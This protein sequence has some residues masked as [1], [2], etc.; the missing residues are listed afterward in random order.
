[1]N[2]TPT[3]GLS[4]GHPNLSSAYWDPKVPAERM[5]TFRWSLPEPHVFGKPTSHALLPM[6]FSNACPIQKDQLNWL[7]SIL[8]S[9]RNQWLPMLPQ[10]DG[11]PCILTIPGHITA[12]DRSQCRD[13]VRSAGWNV[14]HVVDHETGIVRFLMGGSDCPLISLVVAIDFDGLNF[15][16]ITIIQGA[17]RVLAKLRLNVLSAR[18]V[19]EVIVAK[20]CTKRGLRSIPRR[21]NWSALW[22][23]AYKFRQQLDTGSAAALELSASSWE[24]AESIIVSINREELWPHL[25]QDAESCVKAAVE[26]LDAMGVKS[27]DLASVILAGG[28]VLA[29]PQ[30]QERFHATLK[31]PITNAPDHWSAMGAAMLAA[32]PTNIQTDSVDALNS[33]WATAWQKKN[34]WAEEH[35][36]PLDSNATG[37]ST[38]FQP[39]TMQECAVMLDAV[40]SCLGRL[41]D[42]KPEQIQGFLRNV[43]RKI[44]ALS[45]QMIVKSSN[46]DATHPQLARAT[47]ALREGRLDEAVQLSHLASETATKDAGLFRAMINIHVD[48]ARQTKK[49]EQALQWLECA[50]DHD[51]SDPAVHQMLADNYRLQAQAFAATGNLQAA[52]NNAER[53]LTHDPLNEETRRLLTYWQ[54]RLTQPVI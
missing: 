22:M 27:D 44:E 46:N 19:D 37:D 1:M 34:S 14:T 45:Q 35:P 12:S 15:S 43:Q 54:S 8:S 41:K 18:L 2:A 29:W 50:C 28:S 33:S 17:A 6:T 31:R 42:E 48:A 20:A 7:G 53:S 5:Q 39:R 51:Q 9:L 25:E 30:F 32:E 4:I 23:D 36:L 26:L 52:I 24:T 11:C 47:Q 10:S 49:I 21:S 40:W 38:T 3:L 13:L 16:L